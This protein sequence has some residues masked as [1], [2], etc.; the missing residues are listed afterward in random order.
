MKIQLLE[1]VKPATKES[2]FFYY[3][4][5]IKNMP[6]GFVPSMTLPKASLYVGTR[7]A[8]EYSGGLCRH[9]ASYCI[10]KHEDYRYLT[11]RTGGSESRLVGKLGLVGGHLEGNESLAEGVDRELREEADITDNKIKYMKMKGFLKLD[12]SNNPLDVSK[13]HLG[14]VFSVTLKKRNIREEE[15]GI[16]RGIW[17]HKDNLDQYVDRMEDWCL[18]LY[19]EGLFK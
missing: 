15:K 5:D 18:T 19:N 13:D 9:L 8:L 4:R 14:V 17:V 6:T 16:L 12:G 7:S 11:L 3:S 1:R 10:I 2:C